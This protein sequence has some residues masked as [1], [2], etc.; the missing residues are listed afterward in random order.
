MKIL[1]RYIANHVIWG[2]LLALMVLLALFSFIAFVED[3]DL[4]GR[5]D[6]ELPQAVEYMF[7][8][9]PRRA[10]FLFPLAALVGTLVGL[11]IL[12]SNL[13]LSVMRASGMSSMQIAMSVMKAGLLLAV[14]AMLVGELLAPFAERLAQ[15]RR[16]VAINDQLALNSNYGFWVR[17]GRS[18][19]NIRTVL[20]N[21]RMGNVYIYEFDAENRLR[22]ATYARRAE[23]KDREWYLNG[24]SQSEI[25]EDR[26]IRRSIDQAV[27]KSLFQ[28]DL[29]NVVA[30]KPESLSVF[31][32][33]RY[34]RYLRDNGLSTSRYELA[35]WNKIAY[36]VA[37]LAMIFLALPLV[38]GRLR[39]V[40]VGNRIVVGA[41]VGIGFHVINEVSGDM[42]L[43]YGMSPMISAFLPTV[44][45]LG[46]GVLM[47]RRL[48]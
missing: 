23:F 9:L 11:G 6:Y 33:A 13:E 36:P 17:D 45:F 16:S 31:G 43:V 19:I 12:A 24:I 3:L 48:A 34:L 44:I 40:G 26:V 46:V 8:T 38:L 25:Q 30:V 29:V 10:F 32:L 4:V 42:G 41:I 14:L 35:F 20:P 47:M 22:V 7:L 39:S 21:N 27:W 18:F 1:D 28:P 5:G 2:T 37:T 15:Q